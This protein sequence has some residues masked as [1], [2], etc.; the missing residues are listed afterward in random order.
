MLSK[1]MVVAKAELLTTTL[2]FWNTGTNTFDFQIGLM[3]LTIL[4]MDQVFGLRPSSQG[5]DVTHD[6]YSPSCPT[7][8]GLGDS[9]FIIR[10][11]YTSSTF[12][13]YET[14]F[15]DFISFAKSTFSPSSA[16]ANRDKEHMYF[17]LYWLNKHVFLNKSK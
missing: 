4:D 6:W 9:D 12:K 14:S 2:F 15:T 1:T 7:A 5:V 8:E 17:L 3:S 13:S 11:E 10:L 16:T